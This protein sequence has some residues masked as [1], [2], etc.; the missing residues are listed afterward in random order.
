MYYDYHIHSKY[1]SDCETS[2]DQICKKAVGKNISEIAITD[3][4][5]IDYKEKSIQF[6]LDKDSYLKDLKRYQNKYQTKLKIIKGVEIGLQPHIFDQCDA[7]LND[8]FDFI[9]GSFH[10]IEQKD[11]Y[12]GDYFKDYNQWEAYLGYLKEVYQVVK[13]YDNYSV[14]GHFD[15]IRRYGDFDYIPNLMENDKANNL[16]EEILKELIKKNKGIE[17]NTSGYY[18]GDGKNPMPTV[19]ILKL[20]KELGGKIITLGSDSHTSDHLGYNFL[21]TI[22]LL[23][24][25][26]FKEYTVFDKMKP[27]FKK[28]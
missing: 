20:Y 5:D 9:I 26:R 3:H 10:T 21:E 14:I 6:L 15:I 11:L 18:I 12:N 16:I 19:E 27:S 28:L 8:D 23:K 22:K 1:S 13:N 24:S 7:F 17:V 25:I 4:H 2:L